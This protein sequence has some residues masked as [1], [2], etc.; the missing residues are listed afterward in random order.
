MVKLE[1]VLG[2]AS[3][4]LFLSVA[5]A[6]A[7]PGEPP[8]QPTPGSPSSEA[9]TPPATPASSEAAAEPADD[10]DNPDAIVCKRVQP[11]VGSRLG[12]Q[13]VCKTRRQWK[14]EQM[15]QVPHLPDNTIHPPP[16]SQ[17]GGRQPLG[18]N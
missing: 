17:G 3:A 18:S 14:R 7:A 16:G 2:I 11:A 10:D 13:K 4:A 8:A 6:L 9:Q 5:I 1:Q 12:G 15:Q